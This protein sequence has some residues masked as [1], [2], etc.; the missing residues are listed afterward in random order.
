MVPVLNDCKVDC[1]VFGNHDFDYGLENLLSVTEKTKF[2]WLM[3]NVLDVETNRALA[4][5]KLYHIIIKKGIKLGIIGLVEEEWLATLAT[6]DQEDVTYLDFVSEGKKLAKMLKEKEKVDYVIALTHMRCPN[7]CRLASNVDEIDIILGGH[8]HDYEVR[9]VNEKYII[10]SGTDFRTFSKI[11]LHFQPRENE[12]EQ[13]Q[14]PSDS[15]VV[16]SNIDIKEVSVCSD[17]YEEDADLKAKLDK[18]SEVIEG[19]MDTVLGQF[20]CD[21]DGRFA[22]I[23]TQETNLGNFVCDIMLSSTHSDLALLNSGTLRSDRIHPKGDFKLRDLVTIMPMMDPMI[24]LSATGDQIHRALENGVSQWPK[25]EGR[26]PQ[27]AGMKFAFDPNKPPKSRIDPRH[28][29]VGDEPLDLNQRYRLVTKGYL[30]QGKDGYTVLKDCEVLVDEEECPEL[31]TSI[32]NH[33][34]AIKILTDS[35]HHYHTRHRQ[36]LFC[37]SR[38]SSVAKMHEGATSTA[39]S[40]NIINSTGQ[41]SNIIESSSS[42][43]SS[44]CNSIINNNPSHRNSVILK[45]SQSIFH[46]TESNAIRKCSTRKLSLGEIEYEQCK[47]E[48]KVEGRIVIVSNE[49]TKPLK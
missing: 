44:S 27:V 29:W 39:T 17:L 49:V 7:D 8:D 40:H 46:S 25:L 13:Q 1:A 26:F 38:R 6:L 30:H 41:M 23:R 11:D 9:K 5:G 31:C 45:K 12:Q 43:G 42:N 32:Q 15:L 3:S 19:K 21:L 35:A 34:E 18:Y 4:D 10:K 16:C 24:V 20:A 28:I 48:P 22:S 33:F 37:V 47:L 14:K 36:S 2:P